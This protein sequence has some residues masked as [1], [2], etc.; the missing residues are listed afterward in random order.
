MAARPMAPAAAVA[1]AAPM[2]MGGRA[3][4]R[5]ELA[6]HVADGLNQLLGHPADGGE[7]FAQGKTGQNP[8]ALLDA[9]FAFPGGAFFQRMVD[10]MADSS[11]LLDGFAHG[12]DETGD[13]VIRPLLKVQA[14]GRV[15]TN[16]IAAPGFA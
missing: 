3:P 2:G 9:V 7:N 13:R 4:A 12:E 1:A 14:L 10:L 8:A 5:C 16:P 15:V 6:G 11:C